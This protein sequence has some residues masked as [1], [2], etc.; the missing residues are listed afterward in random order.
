MTDCNWFEYE[1]SQENRVAL[2]EALY[3]AGLAF[4]EEISK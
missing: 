2:A 3:Y 4:P 1:S